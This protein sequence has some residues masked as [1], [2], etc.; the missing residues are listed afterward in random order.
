MFL[1]T[2]SMAIDAWVFLWILSKC[3][4]RIFMSSSSDCTSVL[5]SLRTLIFLSFETAF[6]FFYIIEY[7]P[8]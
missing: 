1:K 3:A 2:R 8:S 5:S 4:E 6:N 7:V